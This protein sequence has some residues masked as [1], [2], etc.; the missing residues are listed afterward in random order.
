MRQPCFLVYAGDTHDKAEFYPHVTAASYAFAK[1]ARSLDS[2]GQTITATLHFVAS[3]DEVWREYP[4]RVL[5][6]GPKGA[7]RVGKT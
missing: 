3:R 1:T 5:S 6:L 4:D 7:L 2:F